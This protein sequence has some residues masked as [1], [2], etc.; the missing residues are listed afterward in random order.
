MAGGAPGL[1][2]VLE[3]LGDYVGLWG[4]QRPDAVAW[5]DDTTQVTYRRLAEEV[6]ALAR[7]LRAAGLEPGDR[8]GVLGRPSG[9][10]YTA[11]LATVAAGGVF[12]G[13]N[14]KYSLR[15]LD[16]VVRHARPELLVDTLPAGTTVQAGKATQVLDA[17]A[18]EAA[19]PVLAARRPV[20]QP[21]IAVGHVQSTGTLPAPD[22]GSDAPAIL[23][24]TSGST[25]QPKGALLPHRGLT[26][27]SAVQAER[28][29][30]RPGARVLCNLPIN[31]VGS[32]A[33]I[34]ATTLVAGATLVFQEE[35][36]P[37]GVLDVIAR[38]RVTLWGAVPA[39]FALSVRSPAFDGADLT[40]VERVVFSG[41]AMPGAVLAALQARVPKVSSSYGLT[42]SV[43]ELTFCDDDDP[44]AL[45]TTVGF[46][47]PRYHVAI[48]RP[49]G[50][51]CGVGEVGEIVARGD[52]VFLGYLDD[53]DATA[54]AV[55]AQGWVH[56][57][58]L[59]ERDPQGR[60]RL[61]GRV[62]EMFKSGG[63][64]VYPREI[65][66]AL[67]EHPAVALAAVVPVP[68]PVYGEVGTAYV[69]GG[70]TVTGDELRTYLRGRLTGYKVPKSIRVE[71]DLPLLPIGK[72]DKVALREMARSQRA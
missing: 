46:P 60:F 61:V 24:Y 22:V 21:D 28:W 48:H 49:D 64:N 7:A 9:A 13:L 23:V 57:G 5:V 69:V 42:E 3:R 33:N 51:P 1:P 15:E 25:G 68:D 27:C 32:L 54:L 53:P 39:M 29:A 66:L 65:E 38:H 8:V 50:T 30:I 52:F 26:L 43:G 6:G 36:D 19:A 2:T 41:G 31:H 40:S 16:F 44:A 63:Y 59:A 14:P 55:D 71:S 35:F 37:A 67:E 58:D 18:A 12:F 47:E 62:H 10:A 4:A 20:E 72:V 70:P 17:L 34:M 45:T 56:T 11:Y